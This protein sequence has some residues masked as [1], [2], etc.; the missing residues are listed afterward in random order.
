MTPLSFY[1]VLQNYS[2]WG[3]LTCFWLI[4]CYWSFFRCRIY[5]HTLARQPHQSH[6]DSGYL[7]I[8]Q[9]HK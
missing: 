7:A 9:G 5:W 1:S 8:A 6:L 3:F 2:L 4:L